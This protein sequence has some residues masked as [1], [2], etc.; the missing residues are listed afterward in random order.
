M[1]K[2]LDN[3]GKHVDTVPEDRDPREY[4]EAVKAGGGEYTLDE[5]DLMA[6]IEATTIAGAKQQVIDFIDELGELSVSKYT[7]TEQEGWPAWILEARAF[8]ESSDPADAPLLAVEAQIN[9]M[10]LATRVDEILA[11]AQVTALLP[12]I[13]SGMRKRAHAAIEATGGDPAQVNTLLAKLLVKGDQV[14][15]AIAAGDP[16][17]LVSI[18]ATGWD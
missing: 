2:V 18:A 3:T 5:A 15:D 7:Q 8:K 1:V 9:N 11:A 16:T 4:L 17:A 10:D 12:S 6:W 14:G 13:A